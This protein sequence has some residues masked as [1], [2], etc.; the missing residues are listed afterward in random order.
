MSDLISRQEAIKATLS[1]IPDDE[2]WAEQVEKA[3]RS[4]PSEQPTL[5]GYDIESLKTIA[6]ILLN[7][8][9]IGDT[10]SINI[11]QNAEKR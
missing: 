10:L 7:L 3:I 6:M 8:M 9:K 5:Y 11:A 2:Y 4:L 1:V